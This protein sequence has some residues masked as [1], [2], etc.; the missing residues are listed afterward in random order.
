E[1]RLACGASKTHTQRQSTN[2]S[3]ANSVVKPAMSKKPAFVVYPPPIKGFPFLTVTLH[4]DGTVT[5]QQFE[6]EREASDFNKELAEAYKD[7]GTKH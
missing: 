3:F 2:A 5:G 6:T 7:G 4:P 1:E